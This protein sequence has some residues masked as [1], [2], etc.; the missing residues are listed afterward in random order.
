MK[1]T[2][3]P[4]QVGEVK[5]D[6]IT[7]LGLEIPVNTPI[8]IGDTNIA[9]IKS[10]HPEDYAKYGQYIDVILASPDYVGVNPADDSIEYVKSILLNHEYVKVAVRVSRTG[11]LYVR[12]LYVLN[13]NRV[14]NF[15]ANGTLKKILTKPNE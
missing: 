3:K 2:N 10:K 13:P 14:K 9:H 4:I 8:F 12:S 5:G 7:A 11:N 15:I 1:T 6:V